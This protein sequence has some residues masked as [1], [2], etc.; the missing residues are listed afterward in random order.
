M[1]IDLLPLNEREWVTRLGMR[2]GV[3]FVDG[4]QTGNPPIQPTIEDS[5]NTKK[6]R[7]LFILSIRNLQ[8]PI[9]HFTNPKK[10]LR[11]KFQ[12]QPS[13][14]ILVPRQAALTYTGAVN[15]AKSSIS[16]CDALDAVESNL[17]AS[18]ER[19]G[20]KHVIQE[21]KR[22][23]SCVGPACK[24]AGVGIRPVHYALVKSA[25][26]H[27]DRILKYFKGIEHLFEMYVDTHQIRLIHDAIRFV[28]ATTFITLPTFKERLSQSL[29]IYGSFASGVNVYL[30]AHKDN[31][32]TYGATSIHMREEYNLTHKI[33]AYFLFPKLG[34]AI[35]LR[36]G[37][38]LF[39][40]PQ[41]VHC[42][43]SRCDNNDEIYCM[44]LYFKSANIGKN[45]NSLPLTA[46]EEFMVKQYHQN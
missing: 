22:K 24:R 37:G 29:R 32:F 16:L 41:E 26:I 33:V 8:V 19:G 34:I 42:I 5:D 2:D 43:S 9:P 21:V 38:V 40:N 11:Y 25:S 36:P 35:P 1:S 39:F 28:N 7:T 12:D 10:G 14:I 6:N 4:G 3:V 30:N 27:Q 15:N 31:D 20:K 17:R 13:A 18:V 44:S 46:A 23:Y 45:D